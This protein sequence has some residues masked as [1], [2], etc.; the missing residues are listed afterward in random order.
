MTKEPQRYR[1]AGNVKVRG[2]T[3]TL[4]RRSDTPTS[5]ICFRYQEARKRRIVS[6]S[7]PDLALA[8]VRAKMMIEEIITGGF[9]DRMSIQR[10]RGIPSIGQVIDH[11]ET[12]AKV[13]RERTGRNYVRSLFVILRQARNWSEERAR[14]ERIDILTEPL[15]REW[16]AIR[17]GLAT[18]NYVD[19]MECNTGINSTLRQARALFGR[20]HVAEMES[21]GWVIPDTL[22]GFLAARRV[23]EIS[24]RYI[25]LP[26]SAI[27][28]MNEALP[29]LKARDEKLWAFHLMVRLMGLRS[30]E[31]LRARRHWLLE[32]AG[33]TYLAIHRREGEDAPKR[34]DGEV[35]VPSVLLEWFGSHDCE[36]LIGT[37]NETKRENV[38]RAHSKWVRGFIGEDRTKTNHELRKHAGS[39]MVQKTGSWERAAEFLRIDLETAKSH[40]LAFVKPQEPLGLDDL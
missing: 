29:E 40:Y 25:P 10:P 18:V 16:Q 30:S 31:I 14:T 37:A 4:F 8:K 35:P 33:Q 17:Q 20:R 24:H 23:K 28:A 1:P 11:F 5:P 13:V 19:P 3:F 39:V 32:R 2:K 34:G 22:K 21:L 6:T 36:Y 7:T 26:Q 27:D 15:V 9:D 38:K 12:S